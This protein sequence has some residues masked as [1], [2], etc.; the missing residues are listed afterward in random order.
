[1]PGVT[2]VPLA[3]CNLTHDPLR[4]GLY[5]LGV[6]FAV[7]LM[8]VQLGFRNAML[9]A[10][11]RL[12]D[13]LRCDL[14]LVS[15]GRQALSMPEKFPRRRLEQVRA[16]PGVA[17]VHPLYV[18]GGLGALR[19]TNPDSAKRKPAQGVRVI[20]VDPSAYLIDLPELRPDAAEA[21][22]IREPGTVLFDR[23]SKQD[24]DRPGQSVFGP[25]EEGGETELLGR[26]VRF[27]GGFDLGTDFTVSGSLVM[28]AD[29]FLEVVR[30]PY[31][32]PSDSAEAVVDLG[33]VRLKP[34]ADLQQVREAIGRA[35][36]TGERE[37]DTDVLTK[38]EYAARERTFWLNNT[39]IGFAFGFGM[40]MGF[41]VGLVICYQILSGD[42]SDHLP[43]YATL[44]AIG[45][46][47]GTLAGVVLTEA[48]I[49]AVAGYAIGLAASW[50]AYE[51]LTA[52]TGMPVRM[53]PDRAVAVFVATV[54]M[55][56]VSG[57]IALVGLLRADPADVF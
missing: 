24:P 5:V 25:L 11:T 16:V 37:P 45:Y 48:V 29:T 56:C 35:V 1:M 27:V 36:D 50:A 39:P 10:N 31:T 41:A 43:E 20:G 4:F 3:W 18:E 19:D 12:H 47:N 49:L 40:F 14:V 6:A 28:S 34:G 38:G 15:P 57:L 9:D 51:V 44:K 22:A 55:C 2:R 53:T 23:R 54:A 7:V 42:V 32:L 46:G 30:R 52:S 21:K 8:F 33:L 26:D 13:R 17:E